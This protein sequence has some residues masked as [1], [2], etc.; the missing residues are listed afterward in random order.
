MKKI[1][2]TLLFYFIF[3]SCSINILYAQSVEKPNA[4]Q[5]KVLD[6]AIPVIIKVLDQFNGSDWQVSNDYYTEPGVTINPGVPLDIDQNFEREYTVSE[7]SERFRSLIKPLYDRI[8]KM[9]G[10]QPM[11]TDSVLALG[12]KL[13]ALSN[14][15]VYVYINRREVDFYPNPKDELKI[16][17]VA[18]AQKVPGEYFK[19]DKGYS[20]YL[21]FGNWQ[22]PKGK[23]NMSFKFKHPDN[24]P[25]IENIVVIFFGADDRV[26]ELLRKIDWSV[27]NDALTL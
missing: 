1:K 15:T 25:Y 14:V 21:C 27:L 17:G 20:Y 4:A 23:E 2:Y 7:N 18:F 8:N 5:K 19:S 22:P 11:P 16:P 24:T 12:D 3:C 6:K 26:Q 9:M 10:Q 13:K